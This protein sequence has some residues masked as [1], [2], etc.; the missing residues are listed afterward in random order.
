[1][2]TAIVALIRPWRRGLELHSPSTTLVINQESPCVPQGVKL[3]FLPR[4]LELSKSER[5]AEQAGWLSLDSRTAVVIGAA[6]RGC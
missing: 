4:M 2:T 1:M 5:G 3:L 6:S